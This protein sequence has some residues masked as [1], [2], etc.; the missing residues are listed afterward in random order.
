MK[1]SIAYGTTGLSFVVPEGLHATIARPGEFPPV[2]DPAGEVARAIDAPLGTGSLASIVERKKASINH[3]PRACIVVSDHTRPVP[4]ATI[5]HPLLARL[6]AAGMPPEAVTILVATGLHRGSTPPE[7]ERMLGPDVV[8]RYKVV[9][10]DAKK[11]EELAWAGTS[12]RG[13]PVHVNKQYFAADIKI[14]TGY[15]EPHFFAGYAG[16]RKAI[17]PG[18]SGE[19]TIIENHS[20]KHV[21]HPLARFTSLH[22]NPIHEDALEI[23][24]RVGA[25]FIVNVCLDDHHAI[26]NAAAGGLQ[27][28]HDHLVSLLEDRVVEHFDEAF[29]I[30]IVNNGGYPLDLDL[31]QSV[32][33]MAIGELAVREGGTI[34]AANELRD[35]FGSN[36]FKAIIEREADPASLVRRL[37]S[38]ELVVESQWQVQILARVAMR[39]RIKVVSSMARDQL[40]NVKLGLEWARDMDEALHDALARHGTGASVLILPAGPQLIPRIGTR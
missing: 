5:V 15:V 9:N 8:A 23:A 22:G 17:V 26:V 6:E 16:G 3:A 34:I 18:I 33:S 25:D 12:S 35:G 36:E 27:E 13:T 19:Q 11:V 39:A 40:S 14:L 30:V 2:E 1:V 24:T 10:H 38:K 37:V 21:D 29:D 20:A 28:A 32:K 4:S 7:L 31:Y